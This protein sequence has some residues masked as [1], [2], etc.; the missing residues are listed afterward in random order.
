MAKI[1]GQIPEGPRRTLL[2]AAAASVNSALRQ[3]VELEEFEGLRRLLPL[4]E[5]LPDSIMAVIRPTLGF[6]TA[7]LCLVGHGKILVI[8]AAHWK[9]RITQGQRDEWLGAG[10][11][12]LGRP[13]RRAFVLADRLL[14]SG[15]TDDWFVDA[16]VIF[17]NGRADLVGIK[18]T[19]RLVDWDEAEAFLREFF[20]TDAAG[21]DPAPVVQM[22]GGR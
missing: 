11:I 17:T 5:R 14:F 16:A 6:M 18:G 22:I 8:S 19:V 4:V 3:K 20:G 21:P 9:G 2:R 12:D 13:D 7:D 15:R 1:I 10:R